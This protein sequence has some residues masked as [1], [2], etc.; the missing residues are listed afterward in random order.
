M[1]YFGF[2]V[3]AGR[4]L[5]FP[6]YKGMYERRSPG[7]PVGPNAERDGIIQRVKDLRRSVDYVETR[8]DV[9][10]NRL[11]YFGVSYGA[12]LASVILANEDRFKAAVISSGGF[13]LGRLL[14]EVD[15]INFAPHVHVPL[16]MLNGRDDFTFP[17]DTSQRP[18]FGLLGTAAEDK[19]H[20]VYDG[21]HIFPF[22]R[23]QKDTRS[24]SSA[25][26]G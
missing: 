23:I 8:A 9:D 1:S 26:G 7:G 18:M 22:A 24:T 14:P 15:N 19:R 17:I 10:K 5:L 3:K 6:M 11:G 21:G 2:I 13:P 12:T 20:V 25:S 16:L 4:A